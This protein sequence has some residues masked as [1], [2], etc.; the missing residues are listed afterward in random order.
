MKEIS[1]IKIRERLP[2]GSASK[3]AESTV[4]SISTVRAVLNGQ[5]KNLT[6]LDAAADIIIALR[7]KDNEVMQKFK[8]LD[9]SMV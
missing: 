4:Y 1:L 9:E 7:K 2:W 3:I 8:V 6:I 5:Y